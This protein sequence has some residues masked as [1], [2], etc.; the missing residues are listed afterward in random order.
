MPTPLSAIAVRRALAAAAAAAAAAEAEKA[1]TASPVA[2]MD[3]EVE[4]AVTSEAVAAQSPKTPASKKRRAIDTLAETPIYSTPTPTAE[5]EEPAYLSPVDPADEESIEEVAVVEADSPDSPK[6]KRR[7]ESSSG[8]NENVPPR[9]KLM[10]ELKRHAEVNEDNSALSPD[11]KSRVVGLRRGETL[12]VQGEV[13]VGLLR[14]GASLLGHELRSKGGFEWYDVYAPGTGSLPVLE[15][16]GSGKG[17]AGKV[18]DLPAS[19]RQLLE[20]IPAGSFDAVVAITVEN[21]GSGVQHV[22]KV[23]PLF[24]GIWQDPIAAIEEDTPTVNIPDTWKEAVAPIVHPSTNDRPVVVLCGPKAAGKSMLSRYLV[25]SLLNACDTAAYLDADPGQPEFTPAGLLSLQGLTKPIFGPPFVHNTGEELVKAHFLGATSPKDDPGHYLDCVANLVSVHSNAPSIATAPLV[26]NTPGWTKGT[27]LELLESVIGLSNA[28]HV[29]FLGDR[30]E[31]EI[32]RIVPS[33]VGLFTVETAHEL[34]SQNSKM[35]AADNRTLGMISYFHSLGG[36]KWD[37][38]TSLV[39]WAPWVVDYTGPEAGVDALTV[40]GDE[41]MP[42]EVGLA[43]NG[44]VVGVVLLDAA[45]GQGLTQ[46][47][48]RAQDG[49]PVLPTGGAPLDPQTSQCVGLA[50]IRGIDTA[51]QQLQLLTPIEP[52]ILEDAVTN[53]QKVLLV[54]GQLELPVWLMLDGDKD[55]VAGQKWGEVP[56]LSVEENSSFGKAWRPRR[57]VMRRI[58]IRYL[59]RV[60]WGVCVSHGLPGGPLTEPPDDDA[61][62][63]KGGKSSINKQI[64]GQSPYFQAFAMPADKYSVILP[65]YNERRNLPIITWLLAKTF[66]DN[67]IN[68][69][70]IIVDDNS[71]DGTQEVAKQLEK[72]YG[73]DK[74]LLKPRAGKLGLGTAYIHGLQYCTGNFVIIMDA[75]FSH[76]P[77][78]IPKFIQ[79]QK[80]KKLDIVTGTRYAGDGGVYGWDLKRKT[81]SRG[82][83]LLC[84]I[85]LAPG[86]SDVTGSFRLY[87]KEV[88][89]KII[90]ETKSKGYVFQMEMMVRARANKF[91]IGEVP[92][93]FVDRL[94][95]ESKLGSDEIIQYLKGV[96]TLFTTV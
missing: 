45:E 11:G 96:W 56:Y 19:L 50:I 80:A 14:G 4:Q 27:G 88:L 47:V 36:S 60:R 15:C 78:Y 44:T 59:V 89:K 63:L 1:K 35:S 12:P 69:E 53:N 33:N 57:N 21:I 58:Q 39:G 95:G 52:S 22:D 23:C 10:Q 72:V 55:G 74:I 42:D 9:V 68:W 92:I 94:Y 76:H 41:I 91:T 71:P 8:T 65:T 75:D 40:L 49:L 73:S 77:K 24:R 54:R 16:L 81:I 64:A 32:T 37:F 51:K 70:L 43:V 31:S 7:K 29:I 17:A 25:N 62:T 26:I 79:L 90:S 48:V 93:A 84:R 13:R 34:V 2:N 83:N 20:K 5:D 66:N 3:I 30:F 86:V 18:E 85:V 67:G 82:A 38:S 61:A 6:A 28:T 87:K 46:A